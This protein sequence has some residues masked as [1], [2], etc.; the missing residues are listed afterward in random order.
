[1]V[2]RRFVAAHTARYEW[3]GGRSV[4]VGRREVLI[5]N[6]KK[7]RK[8]LITD[9]GVFFFFLSFR[10]VHKR[11]TLVGRITALHVLILKCKSYLIPS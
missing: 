6:E 11:P 5:W 7:L 10:I 1:M 4:R 2:P 9:S 8:Q 3:L